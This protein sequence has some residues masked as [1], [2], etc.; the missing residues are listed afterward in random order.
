MTRPGRGGTAVAPGTFAYL[1]NITGINPNQGTS[2]GGTEVTLTGAFAPGFTYVFGTTPPTGVSCSSTKCTMVTPANAPGPV[3]VVAQ[4]PSGAG[5][6]VSH[7]GF[8]YLGLAVT[9]FSPKVGP[10]AGGTLV[11]LEGT[12][13]ING[14]T[15]NFGGAATTDVSCTNN[16][17]VCTLLS[18]PHTAGSFPVNVTSNGVTVALSGQFTFEVFPSI[19]GISPSSGTTRTVVTLTGDRVQ[20]SKYLLFVL[21]YPGAGHLQQHDD[22]HGRG[23]SGRRGRNRD[24]RGLRDRK[25]KHQSERSGFQLLPKNQGVHHACLSDGRA[26]RSRKVS[27]TL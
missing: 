14:M 25:R 11:T 13:M 19:T 5:N 9:G 4:T 27:R 24:H 8:T 7:N 1:P 6:S 18:P 12:S 26:I 3:N 17:T 20:Q 15:V 10:T 21:W 22:V 16:G 23:A 2:L